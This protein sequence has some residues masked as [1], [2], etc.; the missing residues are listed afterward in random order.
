M[1]NEKVV[2][3]KEDNISE[4]FKN[5]LKKAELYSD[6]MDMSEKAIYEQLVSDFGEKFT[7][8][9]ANYAINNLK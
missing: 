7:T 2:T 4:E 8:E 9:E 1:K 3:K 5:A 6:S